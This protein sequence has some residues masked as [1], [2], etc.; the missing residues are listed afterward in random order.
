ME[1]HNLVEDVVLRMVDEISQEE[2]NQTGKEYLLSPQCKTD[3]ACFVLNRIPQYYVT[4]G[5][6]MV[7]TEKAFKENPQL[8]VDIVTLIHEG[9][10]RIDVVRRPYY[11]APLEEKAHAGP[12]YY[13]PTIKGKLLKC[14]TFEPIQGV[15]VE[16]CLEDQ[17][18]PMIDKRWQNPFFLDEK[19]E[20]SFL[21]LP[22]PIPAET[23]GSRKVFEFEIQV[24]DEKFEPFHHYF[25]I[26]LVAEEE[27]EPSP[28]KNPD[29]KL[30]ELFLI[31]K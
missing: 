25:K 12:A 7:H 29:Y 9:V 3:L 15:S 26:E 20:G 1:I 31:P 30:P 8:R 24:E 6:G 17:L 2:A 11:D 5:R 19:L 23:L 14:T 18:V 21:F 16:F 27:A 13:I 28:W 10:Q 22:R 4:S